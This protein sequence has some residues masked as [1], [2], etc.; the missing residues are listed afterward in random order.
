MNQR[1]RDTSLD[2]VCTVVGPGVVM[3]TPAL[4]FTLTAL[5][6]TGRSGDL[7]I[8]R[9]RP[10][11]E[12]A[13]RAL[14]I[15][16]LT[17]IGTGI[18]SGQYQSGQWDDG[19]NALAIGDGLLI[20]DERNCETNA[21]LTS[22]GFKVITVPGAEL[23]GIRGG[24]RAMC[25]ALLRD[26]VRT[27][28]AGAAQGGPGQEQQVT[29]SDRHTIPPAAAW[30][31]AAAPAA[32]PEQAEAE[33]QDKH[34][35]ETDDQYVDDRVEQQPEHK[36]D[37]GRRHDEGDDAHH[38]LHSTREP[39]RLEARRGGGTHQGRVMCGSW[40]LR[41]QASRRGNTS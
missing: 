28:A 26:P 21:R 17:V 33:Q 31:N 10:F 23:G 39:V 27:D 7:T 30:L 22:A 37:R 5:T 8:S 38:A 36:E 18:E 6:I 16:Q 13:A 11:L 4:A 19:G 40:S 41:S 15:D 14:G 25:V 32:D 24:P 29:S 3:M 35:P 12:A 9:P 1:D 34:D 20:C 2:L